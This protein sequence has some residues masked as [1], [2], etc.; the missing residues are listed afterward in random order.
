MSNDDND[1][2][3]L[4]TSSDSYIIP[5]TTDSNKLEWDGAVV[6]VCCDCQ[7]STAS[8]DRGHRV[9][10]N[11]CCPILFLSG[12]GAVTPTIDPSFPSI[13][14]SQLDDMVGVGDLPP[15]YTL[16]LVPHNLGRK[17]ARVSR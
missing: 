13:I 15:A 12:S 9:G 2:G 7:T 6:L 10:Y 5:V 11:P 4:S 3:T 17:A 16:I 8:E 1:R 14:F